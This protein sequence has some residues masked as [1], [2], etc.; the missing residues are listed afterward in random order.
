[1]EP[2]EANGAVKGLDRRRVA[3]NGSK[4]EGA[5]SVKRIGDGQAEVVVDDAE[6]RAY[7]RL[8]RVAEQR[9][10]QSAGSMR[11]VRNGDAWTEVLVIPGPERSRAVG[12]AAGSV[13]DDAIDRLTLGHGAGA[14]GNVVIEVE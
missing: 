4:A 12:L 14:L 1:M 9:V 11:R 8:A 6:A 5:V 2:C 3:D 10:E 13:A 7:G